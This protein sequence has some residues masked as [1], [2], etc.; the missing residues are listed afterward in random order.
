VAQSL[1]ITGLRET[2]RGF[3]RLKANIAIE[4]RKELK[5]LAEPVAVQARS[6]L[7][8]YAGASL[9]TIRP[10]ASVR[11]AFVTQGAKKATG[12]R[13]DFGARQM[14]AGLLP[15]LESEEDNIVAGAERML[16]RLTASEG[17]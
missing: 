17:F 2:Q 9:A 11:G 5:Q 10:R 7:S 1:K 8:R 4:F 12:R 14:V 13:G 3:S 6:L 15:A 16:D